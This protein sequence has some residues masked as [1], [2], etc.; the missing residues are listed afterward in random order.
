MTDAAPATPWHRDPVRRRRIVLV[1][2]VTTLTVIA[3]LWTKA[4]AWDRL[5][6]GE[7]ITLIEHWLYFKFGF[8]TG[9]AFSF[10]DD[11]E[12][13]RA[14]FIGI[15]LL[16]LGYMAWLTHK[17]TTRGAYGF[18]AVGMIAGG[19]IGN[20][21]DRFVRQLEVR[22]DG[23]VA[24]RYGVVDFIQFFY[25]WDGGRYWPIFNVADSALVVGVGLLLIYMRGRS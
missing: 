17:M 20:L 16:A 24:T 7:P 5:R 23:E 25:D 21:H 10:L 4:W 11:A 6:D 14:F 15:T 2:I 19:A 8:N 3:D 13:S 22:I 1:L 18:V 9:S 12:W